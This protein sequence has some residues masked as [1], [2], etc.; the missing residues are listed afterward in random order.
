VRIDEFP[1]VTRALAAFKARAAVQRG[2][3]IPPR[4]TAA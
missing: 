3:N 1:E 4:P 2:L